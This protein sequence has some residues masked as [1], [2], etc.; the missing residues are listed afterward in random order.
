MKQ[1]RYLVFERPK[2]SLTWTVAHTSTSQVPMLA[3]TRKRA[4]EHAAEVRT[5]KAHNGQPMR[6]HIARI[7]LPWTKTDER[8]RARWRAEMNAKR[9]GRESRAGSERP[10]KARKD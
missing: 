10:L 1:V 3:G 9:E 8:I 5:R 6:A 4:M 7:E 2:G